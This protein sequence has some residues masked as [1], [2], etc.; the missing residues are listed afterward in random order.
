M[1]GECPPAFLAHAQSPE[2]IQP[3]EGPFDHPSPP[4]QSAALFGVALR[5]PR[6]NVAGIP[7]SIGKQKEYSWIEHPGTDGTSY[8]IPATGKEW[9]C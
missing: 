3:S 7:Q 6:H 5:Q 2:L 1:P 8:S 9:I 4:P